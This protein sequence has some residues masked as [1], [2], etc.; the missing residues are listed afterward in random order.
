MKI[1]SLRFNHIID[2]IIEVRD[3][4]DRSGLKIVVDIRKEAD[5]DAIYSSLMKLTDLQISYKT[6]SGKMITSTFSEFAKLSA[7]ESLTITAES[8]EELQKKLILKME[9]LD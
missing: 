6:K 8:F 2:G 5:V 4:S 9:L 1:D 7:T 3:E